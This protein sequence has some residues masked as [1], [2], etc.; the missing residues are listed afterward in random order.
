LVDFRLLVFLVIA[1]FSPVALAQTPVESCTDTP[2]YK[3]RQDIIL[4]LDKLIDM[5]KDSDRRADLLLRKA[6]SITDQA[7]ELI[8]DCPDK[9]KAQ[10]ELAIKTYQKIVETSPSYGRLDEV[11][12]LLA[13]LLNES[14]RPKEAL[15]FYQQ[16]VEGN[17]KFVP[18]ALVAIGD[19]YFGQANMHMAQKAY[20]Q[21]IKHEHS[22]LADY[23]L[24]KLAWIHVN[25]QD[26]EKAGQLFKRIAVKYQFDHKNEIKKEALKDYVL[27]Y[28]HIGRAAAAHLEFQ[29]L[30]GS[31]SGDLLDRLFR[32]YLGQGKF[33]DAI[34]V[35][36]QLIKT[37]LDPLKKIDL[38]VHMIEAFAQMGMKNDILL[39]VKQLAQTLQQAARSKKIRRKNYRLKYAEARQD[40]EAAIGKITAVWLREV[41]YTRPETYDQ[42][43]EILTLFLR[44]FPDSGEAYVVQIA[45]ADFLY[46]RR[47]KYSLAAKEYERIIETDLA[48]LEKNGPY[49]DG[50]KKKHPRGRYLCEVTYGAL[51]ARQ[52][53]LDKQKLA[54]ELDFIEAAE[55]HLKLCPKEQHVCQVRSALSHSLADLHHFSQ[56]R[57]QL[58]EVESNCPGPDNSSAL[59][60]IEKIDTHLKEFKGIKFE[61]VEIKGKLKPARVMGTMFQNRA[62]LADCFK[63]EPIERSKPRSTVLIEFMI[64]GSGHVAF[65]KIKE[66]DLNGKEAGRCLEYKIRRLK[67]L[68]AQDRQS[69]KVSYRL[70]FAR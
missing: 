57:E 40:A 28:S 27:T 39:E 64:A 18:D 31:R 7:Y 19:F 60:Q 17:G 52:H 20:E 61:P 49:K 3:K 1:Q 55:T 33:N 8:L 59:L 32:L 12:F 43:E 69:A 10:R 25:L 5:E 68:P 37:E 66:S 56:A 67:F 26:F 11:K 35:L 47:R 50:P 44:T 6:V 21:A 54:T 65:S 30:A 2:A 24:Y 51:L 45:Y 29:K 62:I 38:H 13:G 63:K 23:A 46:K 42:L 70:V 48:H 58:T 15:K 22:K 36:R 16:L 53:L 14:K 41:N 9:S 4:R 34:T